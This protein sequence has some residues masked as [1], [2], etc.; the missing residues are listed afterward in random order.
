MSHNIPDDDMMRRGQCD[1]YL[2]MAMPLAEV[3]TPPG[4]ATPDPYFLFKFSSRSWL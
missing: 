1:Q 4:G 3:F 2:R